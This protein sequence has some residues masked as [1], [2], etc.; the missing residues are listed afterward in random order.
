M[1]PDEVGGR[2]I[3][4]TPTSQIPAQFDPFAQARLGRMI[5]RTLS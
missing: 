1:A 4:A 5:G 3:R 2:A